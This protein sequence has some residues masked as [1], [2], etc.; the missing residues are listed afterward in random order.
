M[1]DV[2]ELNRSGG[3]LIQRDNETL[4]ASGCAQVSSHQI[5][6]LTSM[7]PQI[8]FSVCPPEF[9]DGRQSGTNGLLV[10]AISIPPGRLLLSTDTMQMVLAAVVFFLSL[11]PLSAQN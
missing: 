9:T 1:M 7:H 6:L 4:I 3:T 8:H 11:M 2:L 10:I 5:M